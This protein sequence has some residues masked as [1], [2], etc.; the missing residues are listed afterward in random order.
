MQAQLATTNSTVQAMI[1]A[2]LAVTLCKAP[3]PSVPL[4]HEVEDE[5]I[6]LI[7]KK[8]DCKYDVDY[9]NGIDFATQWH[10]PKKRF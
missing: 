6:I 8:N 9:I 3:L 5:G 2:K 10:I 1:R 7:L 4:N